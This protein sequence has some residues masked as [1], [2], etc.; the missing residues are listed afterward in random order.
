MK[1]VEIG[2]CRIGEGTPKICVPIVETTAEKI[3]EEAMAIKEIEADLVEWR[4]DW[5]D[6]VFEMD[7]VNQVLTK[8]K[9]ILS[10]RPILF[11]FRTKKEGG[12]K[13]ISISDYVRLNQAVAREK[14]ADLI[15]VEAFIG[16]EAVKDLILFIHECGGKVLASNHDFEKTPEK[17]EIIRRLCMMQEFGADIVKIAVM[18]R[19]ERDVLNLL[20]ATLEMKEK[21]SDRPVVTMSMGKYGAISRLSGEL[22]G[23]AI[24][25]G[26]RKKASAPGQISVCDLKRELQILSTKEK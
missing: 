25:F 19:N 11:T 4:A 22:F 5:F 8:M 15:D 24:T 7:K 9:E 18:P 23:S 2:G 1:T 26:A 17:K 14:L 13:E 6:D 3:L 16:K 12:E 10:D 21:Y 20:D